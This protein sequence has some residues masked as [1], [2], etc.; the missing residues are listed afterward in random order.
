[1]YYRVPIY[2]KQMITFFLHVYRTIFSKKKPSDKIL[3]TE[4]SINLDLILS[5]CNTVLVTTKKNKQRNLSL[6]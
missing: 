3:I 2:R 5:H 6:K 1:M 4:N